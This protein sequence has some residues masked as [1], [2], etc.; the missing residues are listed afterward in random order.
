MSPA[1]KNSNKRKMRQGRAG[2][3]AVPYLICR[4]VL[5]ECVDDARM[6]VY[7]SLLG[8]AGGAVM[9]IC[10]SFEIGDGVDAVSSIFLP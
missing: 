6:V 7:D 8:Q 3:A 1:V 10:M 5:H 9:A 4:R 2:P